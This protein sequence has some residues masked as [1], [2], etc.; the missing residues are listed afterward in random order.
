[1]KDEDDL[2]SLMQGDQAVISRFNGEF[3]QGEHIAIIGRVGSGKS[4]FLLAILG[5]IPISD[6]ELQIKTDCT[7]A[8]AEQT[9][10]IVSGTI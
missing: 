5:E 8:Y 6:G 9:P 4:S 7:I 3:R 10:L 1:M 2:E